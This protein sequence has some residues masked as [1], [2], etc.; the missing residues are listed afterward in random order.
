MGKLLH[1]LVT[2]AT[3]L[4]GKFVV[5]LVILLGIAWFQSEWAKLQE[6][7]SDLNKTAMLLEDAKQG[8][9]RAKDALGKHESEWK[10]RKDT[11]LRPI[12]N[13]IEAIDRELREKGPLIAEQVKQLSTEEGQ[14]KLLRDAVNAAREAR[15][16]A[17]SQVNWH[18]NKW[19]LGWGPYSGARKVQLSAKE[20]AL[21]AAEQAAAL[22]DQLRGKL[23]GEITQSNVEALNQRRQEK[24]KEL[25]EAT[26]AAS[27]EEQKL[28]DEAKMR[29]EV[30]DAHEETLQRQREAIAN[31]PR[32]R[33][34]NAVKEWIPTALWILAGMTITPLILKVVC[35]FV[36]APFACRMKPICVLP[37]VQA[38]PLPAPPQSSVSMSFQ[39]GPDEELLIHPDFLQSS[40][41]NA[42]KCT[43]FL[44]NP[45]IPFSS[46]ASG[47]WLLTGIRPDDSE[48]TRVV[49]SSQKDAFGEIGSIKLAEHAAMVVHPRSL[50][51]VV[52][53]QG[54]PLRITRHWRIFSLHAWLTFQLRY[55][56][57]HGPCELI[58]KGCRGIR[59]E[60]PDEG[61]PRMINQSITIGFSA[62]LEYK[63]TRCETFIPYLLGK[64]DLFNDLFTG[65]R[66]LFVYEEV[67]DGGRKGG[68]TGRWLEGMLDV[69]LK[70]FGL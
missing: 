9:Q 35:Y 70:G 33:A 11:I 37:T 60:K 23:K 67:P 69:I 27:P 28:R 57:F 24:E 45:K 44:L 14:A 56:V 54:V 26:S 65:E 53:R 20:L 17:R 36:F 52:K 5:I 41:E 22:N 21:S 39:I 51:G 64:E 59:A 34:L 50:A 13:Q 12:Q 32:Q 58:L 47:M 2:F 43:Q 30:V 55:L 6:H 19:L 63:N 10:Q 8:D 4:V 3:S 61:Q 49:V 46:I 42:R 62:N 18:D 1:Q 48:S 29:K 25:A 66:G 68:I 40:S 16:N 31:D 15:D 38:P 7:K